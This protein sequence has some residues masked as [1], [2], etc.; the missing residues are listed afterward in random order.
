MKRASIIS[1][2]LIS[3]CTASF[4]SCDNESKA[5][6]QMCQKIHEQYPLA[7]L[8][9]VYKTCYQDYFGAEH[10]MSDTAA[11]RV[12]L[13]RELVECRD[14]DMSLMP[15]K[16]P[17]GFRHR[18]MRVNLSCIAEGEFSEKQLLAMFF[19]A[20]SKDNAFGDTWA[21][22][23]RKIENIALQFCSDWA[24]EPLQSKLR[25][26]AEGKHAV[27]HSD[28]FRAVYNPHYRIVRAN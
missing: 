15:K 6:R 4:T 17:T 20:A 27:R 14:S 28:A 16:E 12:Y 1:V 13:Q 21:K 9:D 25:L 5:I 7:T 18:F 8:Q 22:E 10:L 26:A 23:W 24:D 19:E 3:I 11:A 2:L